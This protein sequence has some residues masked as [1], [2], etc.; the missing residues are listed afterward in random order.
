MTIPVKYTQTNKRG[1]TF[2][3]VFQTQIKAI[4]SIHVDD[5]LGQMAVEHDGHLKWDDLQEIKNEIWGE[6]VAAIEVYPPAAQVV[7]NLAIRH[8]W[9]LGPDDWWPNLMESERQPRT[10]RERLTMVA[11]E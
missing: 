4:I 3:F 7:N 11:A 8:L 1:D 5:E 6:D 10:L 9:R 2:K